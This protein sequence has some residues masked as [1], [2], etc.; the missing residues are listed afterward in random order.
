MP[1]KEGLGAL[2]KNKKT[3][4]AKSAFTAWTS[5]QDGETGRIQV[6]ELAEASLI[7]AI[8]ACLVGGVYLGF[9]ATRDGRSIKVTAMH[10]GE[11]GSVY[12]SN[13]DE[14]AEKLSELAAL[15]GT[16]EP[17]AY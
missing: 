1:T 10:G 17:E 5:T 15:A 8:N 4:K 14:L 3:N 12:A 13:D 6:G 7:D 11:R 2:N 9:S 16:L